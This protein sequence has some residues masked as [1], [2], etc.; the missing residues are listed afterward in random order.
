MADMPTMVVTIDWSAVQFMDKDIEGLPLGPVAMMRFALD[1][2]QASDDHIK[3]CEDCNYHPCEYADTLHR[4]ATLL[5]QQ[6][7]RSDIGTTSSEVLRTAIELVVNYTTT[8]SDGPQVGMKLDDL[9]ALV[10]A[11]K[12]MNK[13]GGA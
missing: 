2:A 4:L 10:K 6:A 13:E 1:A 7:L 9:T 3:D 5:R 11:V 8:L 12:E